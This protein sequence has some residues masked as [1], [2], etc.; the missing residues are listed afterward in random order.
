MY[1]KVTFCEILEEIEPVVFENN[2]EKFQSERKMNL[3]LHEIVGT[4]Q[5]F[6]SL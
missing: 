3:A 5:K 6:V 4:I 2:S 1:M